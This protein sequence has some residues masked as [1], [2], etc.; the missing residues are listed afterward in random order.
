MGAEIND[1]DYSL[2]NKYGYIE[3]NIELDV[4][5]KQIQPF[6]MDKD[7]QLYCAVC[8]IADV[9]RREITE[10]TPKN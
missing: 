7:E 2:S 4:Q 1:R 5:Y 10:R 8:S 3:A 6:L 9:F